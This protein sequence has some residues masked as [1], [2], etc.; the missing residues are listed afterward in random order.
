MISSDRTVVLCLYGLEGWW[1][2]ILSQPYGSLQSSAFT[3]GLPVRT[4][5]IAS[6]RYI[7]CMINSDGFK[8]ASVCV[9]VCVCAVLLVGGAGILQSALQAAACYFPFPWTCIMPKVQL[10]TSRLQPTW[11]WKGPFAPSILGLHV[12]TQPIYPWL[13]W[14]IETIY[15][16]QSRFETSQRLHL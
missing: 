6:V 12:R 13:P 5:Y 4:Y 11:H 10:I 16:K 7:Q 15:T 14:V 8:L 2:N 1:F 9:Y 3:H